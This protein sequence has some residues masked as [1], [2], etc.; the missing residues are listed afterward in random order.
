M[1]RQS[2]KFR[3]RSKQAKPIREALIARAG[4]CMICGTNTT[5][6][7]HGLYELNQLCCHEIAGGPLRQKFLDLP[8]GILVLCYY[9]N[10]Y[11]VEDKAKW[12]QSRQLSVLQKKSPDSYDLQA[13][14]FAVNPNAPRRIEQHE[15]DQWND[16]GA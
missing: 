14:N 2:A 8:Y 4:E 7:K 6:R 11:E 1:R 15:V 12:P 5:K 16:E 9:C 10:Q 3:E 13:F